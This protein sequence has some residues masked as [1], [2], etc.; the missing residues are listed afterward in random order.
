MSE[1]R[2]TIV[3]A[4]TPESAAMVAATR[5]AM[6][7]C[8]RLNQLTFDDADQVRA[9]FG[10]LVGQELDPGFLLLPPFY[11]SGGRKIRVGRSVFINQNCTFYDLGGLAIGDEVLIGPNVSL[12]TSGHPLDPAERRRVTIGK[13]IAIGRGVW[14]G[15]GAIVLGGVTIGEHAVIA[16]GSV[17]TRDVPANVVV[18]GN[19]ARVI[20][21]I[22]EDGREGE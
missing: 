6:A 15:A 5:R 1:T 19:P 9:L 7:I 22:G 8:A 16:A 21:E 11:C 18:G 2:A 20:R 4:R 14:I 12:L 17:V 10:E 3:H 13:P